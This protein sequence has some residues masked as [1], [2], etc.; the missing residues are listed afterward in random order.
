M[1]GDRAGR[2]LAGMATLY[3]HLYFSFF[4]NTMTLYRDQYRLFGDSQVMP[5]K[6]IWDYTYYWSLLA[7]LFF[8]GFLSNLQGLG[9]LRPLFGQARTLNLGM[10]ALL[11]D[12]GERNSAAGGDTAARDGR[13]LDQY[14]IAWFRELNRQLSD[15]L[16]PDA[17]VA[18]MRIDV[19][20]MHDLAA[21]MLA[22]ARLHHPTIGEPAL[23]LLLDGRAAPAEALLDAAWY[24]E[25]DVAV[26]A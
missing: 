5:L 2:R 16:E 8:S 24:A 20:R 9:A 18:R 26:E 23:E 12:W 21:E 3:Q 7:P 6:V 25:Q 15:R 22:H 10:Q 19:E 17:F 14:R 11:R 1:A 4:E 13:M